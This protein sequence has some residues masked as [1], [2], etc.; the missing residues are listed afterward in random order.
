MNKTLKLLTQKIK[1]EEECGLVGDLGGASE[2]IE[3]W[4]WWWLRLWGRKEKQEKEGV[5]RERDRHGRRRE[6]AVRVCGWD[7]ALHVNKKTTTIFLIHT[8]STRGRERS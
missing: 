3:A 5:A 1:R 6:R 7:R 8:A 4:W 2:G